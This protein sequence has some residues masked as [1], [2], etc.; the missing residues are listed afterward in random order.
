MISLLLF[1]F[2]VL[3]SFSLSF[4]ISKISRD[5]RI[6]VY[7]NSNEISHSSLID[8]TKDKFSFHLLLYPSPF[9]PHFISMEVNTIDSYVIRL[10]N[11]LD[12]RIKTW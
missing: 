9:F 2:G 1:V 12:K 6:S 7:L 4:Q 3:S 10:S 5:S 8:L 11:A